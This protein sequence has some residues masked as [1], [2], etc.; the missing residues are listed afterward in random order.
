MSDNPN[1][2]L[3]ADVEQAD[4]PQPQPRRFAGFP[5]HKW[6]P[7][8]GKKTVNDPNEEADLDRNWFDSPEAADAARTDREAGIVVHKNERVNLEEHEQR[9]G[10]VRNSV[11][12]QESR[13]AGN[14]EPL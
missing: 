3:P 1:Y 5:K 9:H 4:Q 13:D 7:V 8:H 14:L 12:A 6:H 11:Q 2:A 10:V